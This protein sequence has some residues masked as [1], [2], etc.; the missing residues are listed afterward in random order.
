MREQILKI[1]SEYRSERKN[2]F[3]KNQLADFIRDDFR[4][5]V[6]EMVGNEERYIVDSSPGKGRWTDTPWL[7]I[8]D[9]FVT[10]SAQKGY[11]PVFIFRDDMSGLYL[12]LNQGVT[13]IRTNYK[14]AAT[15]TLKIK[16]EDYRA[17]IGSST[18]STFNEKDIQLRI[19]S[20]SDL[21]KYYEAGNIIAKYY[22][23]SNLPSNEVF[24]ADIYEMLEIYKM[25]VYS[26]DK[27]TLEEENDANF[28]A[29]GFE[30]KQFR[31]HKRIERN[32][33]LIKKVKKAQGYTCKA[34]ELNFIDKYGELGRNFIEAHHLK[35]I[36]E[37]TE[38]IIELDAYKDFTVLCSN[39]H[40]MIHR[41]DDPSDLEGFKL[42]IKW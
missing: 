30:K 21:S 33:S 32:Q 23:V 35:P 17:R 16:A 42:M 37:L 8:F 20:D 34:C 9:R 14:K 4:E 26:E 1:S 39:C 7:A 15:E 3:G 11:Y 5:K 40:R 25:L 12:T 2:K 36:S 10:V 24:K 29:K 41:I 13:E 22:S 28:E 19:L 38:E 27:V 18:S 31:Q 6:N